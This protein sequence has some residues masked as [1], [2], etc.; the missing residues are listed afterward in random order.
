MPTCHYLFYNSITSHLTCI[1]KEQ[2][3]KHISPVPWLFVIS[4][5]HCSQLNFMFTTRPDKLLIKFLFDYNTKSI[6]ILKVYYTQSSAIAL[7]QFLQLN[8]TLSARPVVE[9]NPVKLHVHT[10]KCATINWLSSSPIS[11]DRQNNRKIIIYFIT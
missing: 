6:Q 9:I 10:I 5:F 8:V 1:I 11:C 4:G 7:V 3:H 2:R